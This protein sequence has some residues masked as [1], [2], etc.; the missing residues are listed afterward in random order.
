MQILRVVSL[1]LLFYAVGLLPLIALFFAIKLQNW[2]AF[3]GLG[4][5][6][7]ICFFLRRQ[8]RK[9]QPVYEFNATELVAMCIFIS[10]CLFGLTIFGP[11]RF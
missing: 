7:V 1:K 9:I 2:S 10:I 3:L 4:G 5:A 8:I 6:F 11:I